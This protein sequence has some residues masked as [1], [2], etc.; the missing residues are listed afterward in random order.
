[1]DENSKTK[2]QY[3]SSKKYVTVNRFF[4][5]LITHDFFYVSF[6]Q[7]VPRLLFDRWTGQDYM[8]LFK[9]KNRVLELAKVISDAVKVLK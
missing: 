8:R 1:M 2:R 5:A 4:F 9:E 7:V 3:I 6:S